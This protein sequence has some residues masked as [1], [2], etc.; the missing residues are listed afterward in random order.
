MIIEPSTTTKVKCPEGKKK[1]NP[2]ELYGLRTVKFLKRGAGKN[3]TV[4]Y[5][6]IYAY[7]YMPNTY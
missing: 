1:F 5:I 7:I 3:K 2:S 6:C 4:I